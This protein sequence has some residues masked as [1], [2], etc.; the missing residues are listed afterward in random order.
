MLV[1]DDDMGENAKYK[2]SL[3]DAPKYSG[4][5]K[6]FVISPEESQGRA[7]VVIRA[8]DSKV[9]DYDVPGNRE[10]EFEVAASVNDEVVSISNDSSFVFF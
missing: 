10:L 8:Q 1:T 4:V 3:R 6:A 9:L 5:S 7:T 2:L